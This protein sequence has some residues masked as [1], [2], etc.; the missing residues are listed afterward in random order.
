[1]DYAQIMSALSEAAEPAYADF[2]SR[3]VSDTKYPILGVRMPALRKLA[4]QASGEWLRILPSAQYSS[5]EEVMVMGL[6]VA[7]AP[8]SL[9]EKLSALRCILPKLDSWGLTDSIVPTLKPSSDELEL[10]WDFALEC[11]TK[12]EAYTV[13]FGIVLMLRFFL[14]E[15]K[16]SQ[17]SACLTALRDSRYYVNMAIAWCLAEMAVYDYEIVESILR[18][19][20]LTD[21]THQKTIQKMRDSFRFTKE[22]KAAVALLRRK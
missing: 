8:A 22:Q 4:K 6:M 15:E 11:M 19:H 21:F 2:Q 5:Y 18:S 12:A 13:R 10:L 20:C 16:I 9:V 1:M 17:V 14:T 3:I 7:Y